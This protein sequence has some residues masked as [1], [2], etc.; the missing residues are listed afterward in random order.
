MTGLLMLRFLKD[1][2]LFERFLF[3]HFHR[4]LRRG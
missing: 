1:F 2:L 3:S 4:G